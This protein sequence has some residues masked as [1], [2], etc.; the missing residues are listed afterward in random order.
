MGYSSCEASALESGRCTA[1]VR[2]FNFCDEFVSHTYARVNKL[3]RAITQLHIS[4][5]LPVNIFIKLFFFFSFFTSRS[6]SQLY[7]LVSFN[8]NST[9]LFYIYTMKNR[10]KNYFHQVKYI[11]N[12]F[13]NF[14]SYYDCRSG[15]T[16]EVNWGRSRRKPDNF[17]QVIHTGEA[18][19]R[20]H[21][22]NGGVK[23]LGK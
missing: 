21:F 15:E 16:M 9:I 19:F 13:I 14:F 8:I 22:P 5:I 18:P 3:V 1:L 20:T 4:F 6:K 7:R 2:L 11:L 17:T 23:T 12:F 10:T